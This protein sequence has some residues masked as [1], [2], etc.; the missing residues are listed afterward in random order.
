V[1]R[2]FPTFLLQTQDF[3][4]WLE[5]NTNLHKANTIFYLYVHTVQKLG[6]V[7]LIYETFVKIEVN[8]E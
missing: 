3:R 7:G 6:S 1:S 2:G 8:S 5:I 4:N